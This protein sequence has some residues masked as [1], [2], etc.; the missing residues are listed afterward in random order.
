VT[1]TWATDNTIGLFLVWALMVGSTFQAASGAWTAPNN[2][3][4]SSN[5]FN[6]LATNGN[7]FELFDVSLT[8]GSVAPPFQVPDYVDELVACRR[9]YKKNPS[10]MGHW[11]ETSS[12]EAYFFAPHTPPMRAGPTVATLLTASRISRQVLA[13]YNV[14][15]CTLIDNVPSGTSFSINTAT[16]AAN[17]PASLVG[18]TVSFNARL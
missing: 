16:A 12:T 11:G 4:G 5:Q 8:E 2:V 9:Y 7:V 6:F 3:F 1:G 10:M 18:D 14:G 17:V 15:P 13:S